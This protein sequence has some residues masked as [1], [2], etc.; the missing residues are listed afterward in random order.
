MTDTVEKIRIAKGHVL[1]PGR[2]LLSNVLE[3]HVSRHN[4]KA[5]CI[6]WHNRAVASQVFATTA[7]FRIAGHALLPWLRD[8]LGVGEWRW[9]I[10]AIWH[11]KLLAL[12]GDHRLGLLSGVG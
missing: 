2:N 7:R 12:Q 6:H 1:C 11:Q 5:P 10:L 9:E 4:A 8:E 3:D